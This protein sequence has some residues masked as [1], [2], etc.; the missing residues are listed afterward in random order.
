MKL[1]TIITDNSMKKILLA[2]AFFLTTGILASQTKTNGVAPFLNYPLNN[3][4]TDRKDL[5]SGD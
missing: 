3:V 5:A 2:T 4:L 1:K